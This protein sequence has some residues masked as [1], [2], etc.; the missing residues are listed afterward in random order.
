[1]IEQAIYGSQGAGGYRFLARSPGF[2]DEW[3]GLP[4]RF[5]QLLGETSD[6]RVQPHVQLL[7]AEWTGPGAE[8]LLIGRGGAA[9][10]LGAPAGA[11]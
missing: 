5:Y 2:R 1:M 3:V 9:R 4:E 11:G 8:T 6:T 10:T 7:S